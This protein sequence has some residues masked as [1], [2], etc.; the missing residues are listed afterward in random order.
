MKNREGLLAILRFQRLVALPAK[1]ITHQPANVRLVVRN[2][3]FLH[4]ASLPAFG[5]VS[6]FDFSTAEEGLQAASQSFYIY[7]IFMS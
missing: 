3:N 5:L 2:Q 1:K 6:A 7:A 4:D